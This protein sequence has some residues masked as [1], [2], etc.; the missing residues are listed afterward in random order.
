MIIRALGATPVSVDAL[1]RLTGA[2][3]ITIRR[4]LADLEGHGLLRRVHGGALAVDLRGTPLPYA[5]RATERADDKAA[6]AGVIGSL[7]ADH[8]SVILDNGSTMDAVAR[9]LAGR[10]VTALCM[11]LRSAVALG[12]AP[13]A[14]IVVP[15]GRVGGESLRCDAATSIAAVA[16][17]RA[18]LAIIGACSTNPASGLTVTTHDDAQVKRAILGSS[19][20]VVIAVT[21][22]KMNRTSS[23]RFADLDDIDDLVTTR[24]AP[25]QALLEFRAAGVRVHLT[26]PLS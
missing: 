18:D 17:F 25:E 7:V 1:A 9:T 5:L 3:A 4:D 11:S 10:P 16:D 14:T 19:A 12:D 20:R 15:G 2:S 26:D 24:D 6:I 21:G 23:F 8:S 22:D 13:G